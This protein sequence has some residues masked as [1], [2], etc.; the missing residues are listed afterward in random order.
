MS[1]DTPGISGFAPYLPPY[2]VRLRDWCDWNDQ[3]WDKVRH[4]VGESF[5]MRGPQQNVYTLAANAALRLID[6]YTIDPD[7]IGFL[8]L[9]TESSTDNSAGAVIVKGMLDDALRTRGQTPIS[10]ACE[11]PEYKHACLGGVYALKGALRYVGADGAGRKAVVIA[12]D[13]AEYALGS[14]GEPTQG[15]GAVAMLVEAKPRLLAI[16]LAAAGNAADYRVLDFRKPLAR[17]VGQAPRGD[18]QIQD[19]PVFNGHYSTTCYVDAV[20][21]AIADLLSRNDAGVAWLRGLDAVFM[22]RPYQRMPETGWSLA[23]LYALAAQADPDLNAVAEVAEVDTAALRRELTS[24]PDVAALAHEGCMDEDAYPLAMQAVRALRKMDLGRA[25]LAGQMRLGVARMRELGNLYTAA[26]PAWLAAGLE[27]AAGEDTERTDE[28][29]LAIG[30]G[31]GDAAEAMPM[32][33]VDGWRDAAARIDFDVALSGAI[34]VGRRAYEALHRGEQ[35][36]APAPAEREHEFEVADVDASGI[37][38][39]RYVPAMYAAAR[40]A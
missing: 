22:H 27:Q 38:R 34:D 14:S 11:V 17:F 1:E 7:E 19:L 13:I 23:Y 4:V 35:S 12:A 30:Y 8:A 37:E 16:D 2:R 21:H 39:Y 5:R 15:A 18:R 28:R 40:S 31:S 6:A 10:R 20:R 25:L 24:T 9:A 3:P 26:L 29:W 36:A 32:R 33:V